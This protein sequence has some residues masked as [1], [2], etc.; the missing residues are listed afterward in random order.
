MKLV[1]TRTAD[2]SLEVICEYLTDAASAEVAREIEMK[3]ISRAEE[4]LE[5]PRSGRVVP[6]MAAPWFRE[7]FVDAFRIIY[8]LDPK[9][10]VET[11]SILG[12][13]H[14]AQLL[15]NTPAWAL[16]DEE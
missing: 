12:I 5:F 7:V 3:I 10:E 11:V 14:A 6:E 4:I 8:R 13:A 9:D 15:E 1:W 16:L 2:E